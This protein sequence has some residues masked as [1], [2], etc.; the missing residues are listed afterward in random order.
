MAL[1]NNDITGQKVYTEQGRGT[2]PADTLGSSLEAYASNNP[3]SFYGAGNLGV[4]ASKNTVLSARTANILLA[5][6]R[7]YN[8]TVSIPDGGSGATH[9]WGP[10]GTTTSF[11]MQ[12]TPQQMNVWEYA[13]PGEWVTV[14]LYFSSANRV[15]ESSPMHTQTFALGY[16]TITP[17]SGHTRN[18]TKKVTSPQVLALTGVSTTSLTTPDILY[19]D[20]YLSHSDG[21]RRVNLGTSVS[22]G[23]STVNIDEYVQPVMKATKSIL[24]KDLPAGNSPAGNPWSVTGSRFQIYTASTPKDSAST[25]QQTQGSSSYSFYW[26]VVLADTSANFYTAGVSSITLRTYLDDGSETH[27]QEIESSTSNTDPTTQRSESGTLSGASFSYD[28]EWEVYY[29]NSSSGADITY[30]GVYSAI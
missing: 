13:T 26:T 2:M 22:A 16:S 7:Q 23:Y 12:C 11:N 9:K 5:D 10:G 30:N 29:D 24:S 6:W 20:I 25:V 21:T 17:L 27:D 18:T 28:D 4:D 1:G 19:A 3:F 15:S 14:K 8:H